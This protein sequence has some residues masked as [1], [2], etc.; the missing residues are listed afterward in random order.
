VPGGIL[1]FTVEAQPENDQRS[2]RLN[3]SGRYAHAE[4]YVRNVLQANGFII[5]TLRREVLRRE[6]G[7]DVAGYLVRAAA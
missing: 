4:N 6:I 2:F 1:I 3:V 7:K 5:Q